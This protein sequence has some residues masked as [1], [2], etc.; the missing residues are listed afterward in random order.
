MIF[1]YLLST[2]Y[3]AMLEHFSLLVVK[4]YIYIHQFSVDYPGRSIVVPFI[5]NNHIYIY[6]YV[7]LIF[8]PRIGYEIITQSS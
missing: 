1:M 4:Q 8:I 2:K 6:I 7:Y 3:I 5:N